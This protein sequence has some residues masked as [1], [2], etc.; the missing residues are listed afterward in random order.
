MD[1]AGLRRIFSLS[2]A[3]LG[4]SPQTPFHFGAQFIRARLERAKPLP[5]KRLFEFWEDRY[6]GRRNREG[7]PSS[8]SKCTSSKAAAT[9]Y[10]PGM[11]AGSI[12]CTRAV[13]TI[14][15]LP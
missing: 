11:A 1:G 9:P 5:E 2:L 7:T 14:T 15:T 8:R 3:E 10:H 4:A 6:Q 13:L 12:R